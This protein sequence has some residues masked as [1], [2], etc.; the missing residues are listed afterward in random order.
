MQ[1]IHKGSERKKKEMKNGKTCFQEEKRKKR[2][3]N[4]KRL[5]WEQ[6]L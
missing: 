5:Y 2:M 6:I 1:E 3:K 4:K